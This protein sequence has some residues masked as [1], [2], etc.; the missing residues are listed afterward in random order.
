MEPSLLSWKE[1]QR[2]TSSAG[3]SDCFKI[4]KSIK[5]ESRYFTV[6]K[7]IKRP[8]NKSKQKNRETQEGFQG[9]SRNFSQQPEIQMYNRTG[10]MY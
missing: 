3:G 9:L 1:K 8:P 2:K 10:F 6:G 4:E 7:E 5:E